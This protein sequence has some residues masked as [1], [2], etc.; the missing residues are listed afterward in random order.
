MLERG[1]QRALRQPRARQAGPAAVKENFRRPGIGAERRAVGVDPSGQIVADRHAVA[2]ITDRALQQSRRGSRPYRSWAR[3][4]LSTAPDRDR[5]PG[6]TMGNGGLGGI[7][8]GLDAAAAGAAAVQRMNPPGLGVIDQP[9]GVT[10]DADHVRKHDTEGSGGADRGVD[11]AAALLEHIERGVDQDNEPSPPCHI[12]TGIPLVKVSFPLP[13]P[14]G[15]REPIDC[16]AG[17]N[18]RSP[19]PT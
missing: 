11:R 4:Q 2:R 9:E 1:G 6:T 19:S 8:A 10:A 13:P 17:D 7:V 5:G 14:D 15:N 3:R 16:R 18:R 12:P